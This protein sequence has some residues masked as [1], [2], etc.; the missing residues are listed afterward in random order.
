MGTSCWIMVAALVGGLGGE[1]PSL[2]TPAAIDGSPTGKRCPYDFRSD[3]P[4]G[5]YCVYRGAIT[6]RGGATCIHDAVMIW[7]AHGVVPQQREAVQP[8][9]DPE[10]DV[11]LGFVDPPLVMRAISRARMSAQ[12]TEYSRS[13]D[14]PETPIDGF[15][16]LIRRLAE[17]GALTMKLHPSVAVIRDAGGPQCDFDS[18]RGV[19]VGVIRQPEPRKSAGTPEGR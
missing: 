7:S 13:S 2:S 9:A 12:L 15:T 4:P 16:V 3:M 17:R 19:F 10:R 18:Y 14:R 6:S 11:F 8:Q 1:V 5:E